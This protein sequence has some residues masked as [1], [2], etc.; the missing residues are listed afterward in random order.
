MH[1]AALQ[2][3]VDPDK[4]SFVHAVRVI[5]RK[6]PTVLAFPP[7]PNPEI[8]EAVLAEIL[9]VRVSSSRGRHNPRAI[10]RKGQQVS[11]P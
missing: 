11:H 10:K 5:K 2:E 8:H 1:Q 3:K 4:L 7:Q 9:E 6:L